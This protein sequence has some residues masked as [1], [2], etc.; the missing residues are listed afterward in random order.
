MSDELDGKDRAME[1]LTI[2]QEQLN[3]TKNS[4][5][6]YKGLLGENELSHKHGEFEGEIDY[7]NFQRGQIIREIH[8]IKEHE[9]HYE[10]SQALSFTQREIAETRPEVDG[11]LDADPQNPYLRDLRQ[12][13]A[14]AEQE[15]ESKEREFAQG[16]K[17]PNQGREGQENRGRG[18]LAD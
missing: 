13:L 17:S 18:G 1:R 12:G 16:E 3:D 5:R 2:L 8:E 6:E 4:I 15:L 10:N 7:L 9:N 14:N 11:M